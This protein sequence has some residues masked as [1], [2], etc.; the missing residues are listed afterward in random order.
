MA[1]GP[2]YR[3]WRSSARLC[4]GQS[5]AGESRGLRRFAILPARFQPFG[6]SEPPFRYRHKWVKTEVAAFRVRHA[7][8]YLGI[9]FPSAVNDFRSDTMS[10]GA[11]RLVGGARSSR[12]RYSYVAASFWRPS[13]SRGR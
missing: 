10:R 3:N 5:T 12:S 6:S 13:Q 1:H 11:E 2:F 4:F 8:I 9:V 7:I